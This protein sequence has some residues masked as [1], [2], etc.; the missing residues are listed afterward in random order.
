MSR[1]DPIPIKKAPAPLGLPRRRRRRVILAGLLL[2]LAAFAVCFHRPIFQG[3]LGVVDAGFVYRSAQP[4]RGLPSLI[5]SQGL[6]SVVNLRGGGPDDPWYSAE[7]EVTRRSGVEFYDLPM[8]AVRRPTRGELLALLHLFDTCKYPLL[9]HC[10]SGADRTGLAS[11]LYLMYRRGVPPERAEAAFNLSHG[12]I[13]LFGPE[14]LHEP[15]DEYAAW[16]ATNRLDHTPD[17]LLNWVRQD[18]TADDPATAFTPVRPG[19]RVRR[20]TAR[21]SDAPSLR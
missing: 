21:S 7:V 14:R 12:H 5:E 18:Y 19:P 3:N 11:G 4:F 15:F 16:L 17:R 2:G 10:K 9:I 6:G 20:Q 13:P 8:S 1:V